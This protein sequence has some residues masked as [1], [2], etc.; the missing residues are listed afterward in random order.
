MVEDAGKD[1]PDDTAGSAVDPLEVGFLGP[2]IS[3]GQERW[4]RSP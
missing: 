1:M 2:E 3:P 4:G